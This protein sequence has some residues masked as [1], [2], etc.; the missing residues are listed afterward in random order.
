M[1]RDA[2]SFAT[3]RQSFANM[4]APKR[5]STNPIPFNIPTVSAFQGG[6]NSNQPSAATLLRECRGIAASAQRAI[7][8]RLATLELQASVERPG[9]GGQASTFDLLPPTHPLSQLLKRPHP[10]FSQSQ[11]LKLS[12]DWIGST[13]EADWLKVGSGL[14]VPI[15]LQPIPPTKIV[16]HVVNGVV[17]HYVVTDAFGKPQNVESDCVIRMYFPDPEA[18][19]AAEGILGPTG[20]EVDSLKF[21]GE[22][23]KAY[24][25]N[26]ATPKSV[27]KA[28]E[29]ATPWSDPEKTAF[30][31][32][33]VAANHQRLGKRLGLP[34]FLPL[35]WDLIEI[36]MQSGADVVPLLTYWRDSVL[37][38]YGVPKSVLGLVESG[39]RS[40]AETN[41]WVF[42]KHSVVPFTKVIA[43][44]LTYQLAG[45]FD[46]K[47]VV[48]FADFVFA[49]KDFELKKRDQD[50]RTMQLS[51]N[52]ALEIDGR[53][54]VPWGD[55]PAA[56]F[57]IA[58]YRPDER[59][60]LEEDDGTD[61]E[62]RRRARRRS[63]R[64]RVITPQIREAWARVVQT[65]KRFI[66]PFIR[67]LRAVFRLQEDDTIK[68]WEDV[69]SRA[70][71]G[72]EEIFSVDGWFDEFNEH[73]EPVR[74]TAFVDTATDTLADL[75]ETEFEFTKAA[76]KTL[77]KQGAAMVVNINQTTQEKIARQLGIGQSKGES[78]DQISGRIRKVFRERSRA[79]SRV[80]A[81][82]EI[83]K[84][85]Q[86]AQL[87][88]FDQSGVVERKTW[89]TSLDPEVRDSHA[90]T[91]GQEVDADEAFTLGDGERADAPGV[92]EGGSQ[93]SAGNAISCRCFVT[94]VIE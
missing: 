26:D 18:P 11:F 81:R 7:S 35:N 89:N 73:T 30:Y 9:R 62:D 47:I 79:Q 38:A 33:W 27:L 41:E 69:T 71:A 17:T 53:D 67:E 5:A 50:L 22:H 55:D 63:T 51:V 2:V 13:G 92:G 43:D 57:S 59:F 80:I 58:P 29:G 74:K 4:I 45:D 65:E 78:V 88:G 39:D 15:E 90:M 68:N 48:R 14:R 46:E 75:S 76:E 10:N 70:R 52:Q 86:S 24:Y 61:T 19:H 23:Q 72:V 44:A 36:A 91:E 82:T 34:A 3:A 94:P 8:N 49:D 56:P 31:E 66:P 54:P 64:E 77:R 32:K 84:A 28:K 85:G 25:Q 93:L 87:E 16:P 12:G 21:A 42:D 83:L 6:L 40:S 37:M 60:D 1:V 20:I